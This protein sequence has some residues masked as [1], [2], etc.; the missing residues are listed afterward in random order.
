MG[1]LASGVE[2]GQQVPSPGR[3]RGTRA[4]FSKETRLKL[5]QRAGFRCSNPQCGALT[6]GPGAGPEGVSDT[7]TAS[8]IFAAAA[9]G[10][11][12]T[13][14]LSDEERSTISNGIWMCANCGRLVDVNAGKMYSA[15]LL[16]SWKDLHENRTR[17]E[18]GGHVQP[19]GWVQSLEVTSHYLFMPGVIRLS[20]L[21][22]LFGMNGSGK[23][24]LF[25]L[26]TCMTSPQLL[27]DA[28]FPNHPA[29][30]TCEITW[31]DPA[32][33]R[34]TVEVRGEALEYHVDA[35]RVPLPPRPYRV[36]SF[37]T[38]NQG[39]AVDLSTIGGIADFLDIDPW[40]ARTVVRSL[41]DLLP[42]LISGV[43]VSDKGSVDIS[44][45]RAWRAAD[46]RHVFKFYVLAAFAELQAR[47]EPTILVLDE[48]FDFMHPV[49]ELEVLDLFERSHWTFQ[50]ILA[51]FSPHAYD[52]R[53]QGWSATVLMPADGRKSRISQEDDDV[54]A[55]NKAPEGE[56]WEEIIRKLGPNNRGL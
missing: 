33:R 30:L 54:E 10:P 32:L 48:P 50:V 15:S 55:I 52:R 19:F 16:R 9:G 41:P 4:D 20:K 14:G 8:H 3:S 36:W 39:F 13:G 47:S 18:Q 43:T 49:M 31:F 34:A 17:L 35:R 40:A 42:D 1:F 24:R 11:R 5:A 37:G 56:S 27:M 53:H 45:V 6:I 51:T 26:L 21:N 22:L 2:G 7:G 44:S 38:R 29:D 23:T 28:A 25:H 12:G 46:R